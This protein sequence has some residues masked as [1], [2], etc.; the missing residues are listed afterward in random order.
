MDR[1]AI[2]LRSRR[3][4]CLPPPSPAT[5]FFYMLLSPSTRFPPLPQQLLQHPN[6]L[7]HMLLLQQKRRQEPHHGILRRIKKDALRQSLI[8]N[9][10][11]RNRQI[12]PLNKSASA[13]FLGSSTL[14]HNRP[15]LLLQV[16]ANFI[17]IVEQL[18]IFHDRQKLH[19]FFNDTTT[20]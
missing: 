13:H 19:C 17:H 2:H 4:C 14:L 20:T 8:R 18:L 3:I 15:Q 9:W 10:T 16:S 7:I 6:P 1:K 5:D 11:R 12:D